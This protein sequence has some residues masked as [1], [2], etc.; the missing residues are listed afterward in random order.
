MDK[1]KDRWANAWTH[2]EDALLFEAIEF[3]GTRHK[4]AWYWFKEHGGTRPYSAFKNRQMYLA[5]KEKGKV[6]KVDINIPKGWG[7]YA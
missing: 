6:E 5:L 3:V 2:R 1:R 7:M 4:R